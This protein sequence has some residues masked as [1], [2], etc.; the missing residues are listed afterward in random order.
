MLAFAFTLALELKRA[1]ADQLAA[2]RDQSGAAPIR[3]GRIGEDRL[4][5]QIFPVTGELLLVGDGPRGW[6]SRARL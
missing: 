4:I 6:K 1:D 5:K 2:I 3:M